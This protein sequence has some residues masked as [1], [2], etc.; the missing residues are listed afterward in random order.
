MRHAT[1]LRQGAGAVLIVMALLIGFN[2]LAGL[3]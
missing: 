1:A 3:Q 2:T